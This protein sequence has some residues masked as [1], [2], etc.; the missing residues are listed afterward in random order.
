MKNQPLYKKIYQDLKKQIFTGELVEDAQLPTELELSEMYEVSRITSKR[1]LVE[2]ETEGLIYRVRGKGS[3]VK[4]R[5]F[6]PTTNQNDTVLF[7]MPFA[8]NEGFGNYAEGILESFKDTDFRLQMQPHEWLHSGNDYTLKQDYA[9]IIYYPINTQVSLDFLYKCQVQDIPVVIL[10]KSIEKIEYD[11]VVADNHSG[12][13]ISAEYFIEQGIEDIFFISANRLADVSSV[14]DRYLGYLSTMY[15]Q[16]QEPLHLVND[17][18]KELEYF[19]EDILEKVKAKQTA[20]NSV[21]LVVENDVIA[22]RLMTYLKQHNLKVPEDVGIIGFD[23]I[24]AASLMDPPLT[25]IAQNFYKMGK[26]AGDL[27][28][29]QINFPTKDFSEHILPVKLI[30][31]ESGKIR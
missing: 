21:G 11:S 31:R 13:K 8:Q 16:Q 1:A 10:D 30:E 20:K 7:I 5:E 22:I 27:L 15:E 2:L 29:K 4:K 18:G 9:G 3:F 24:Q 26:V 17:S 19:F 23:N 6:I 28:V 14:R 12:G 25:T